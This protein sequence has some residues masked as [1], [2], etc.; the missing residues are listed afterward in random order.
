[1]IEIK[2]AILD[3]EPR[4]ISSL[5]YII[6]RFAVS[7]ISLI[8]LAI[9]TETKDIFNEETLAESDLLFLDIM[10]A[11][12]N[13]LQLIKEWDGVLPTIV[14][15]SAHEEFVIQALRSSVFDYLVKPVDP[16]DY[17]KLLGRL[18]EKITKERMQLE[19]W[20]SLKNVIK[21]WQLDN[22]R[23]R[24]LINIQ[25]PIMEKIRKNFPNAS[26]QDHRLLALMRLGYTNKEIS[27][28]LSIEPNS[29][30]RAKV[31]L[32]KKLHLGPDKSLYDMVASIE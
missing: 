22:E 19:D 27:A 5:R 23:A 6:D 14:V 1:M 25:E 12:E 30:K 17:I 13:G 20:L 24:Q 21:P 7:G 2:Y 8:P 4:S 18:I 28:H 16:D 31:R 3:D 15:I 10:L 11:N 29:V 32:K 9:S 26:T